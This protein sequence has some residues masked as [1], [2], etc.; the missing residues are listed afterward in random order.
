MGTQLPEQS[1]SQFSAHVRC[2]HVW[3]TMPLGREVGPSPGDIVLDEDQAPRP[4]GA[5]PPFFSA[6]TSTTVDNKNERL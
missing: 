3:I 5:Q 4:K 1:P 6:H 2:G